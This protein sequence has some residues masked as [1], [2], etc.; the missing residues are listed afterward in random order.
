[1]LRFIIISIAVFLSSNL[2]AQKTEFNTGISI[3]FLHF[4]GASVKEYSS[5]NVSNSNPSKSYTNDQYGPF[6]KPGPG[7]FLSLNHVAK[8][9]WLWGMIVWA[10]SLKNK[11]KIKQIFSSPSTT[12]AEGN[13]V[14]TS[15]SANFS[16]FTGYRFRIGQSILFDLAPSLEFC[17]FLAPNHEKGF[18]RST[19][20]NNISVQTDR[21]RDNPVFDLRTGVQAQIQMRRYSLSGGYWVGHWNY[22]NGYLGGSPEAYSRLARI[23]LGYCLNKNK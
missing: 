17:V 8:S 22:Y 6:S 2:F 15:T 14:F 7:I 12:I 23:G 3:G 19:G 1:M 20:S 16:I 18:A 21:S 10:E 5:I 11:I 9:K 4:K 13:T